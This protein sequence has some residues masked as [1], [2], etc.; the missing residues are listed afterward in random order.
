MPLGRNCTADTG[1]VC[2]LNVTKQ[3]PPLTFHTWRGTRGVCIS[4]REPEAAGSGAVNGAEV[5]DHSQVAASGTERE[6]FEQLDHSCHLVPIEAMGWTNTTHV[7][8]HPET[9]GAG[10]SP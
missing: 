1:A 6:Q 2:S 4:Q 9:H 10:C 5:C 3:D 7:R 8:P